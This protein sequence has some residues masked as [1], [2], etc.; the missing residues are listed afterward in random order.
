MSALNDIIENINQNDNSDKGSMFEMLCLY[1]LRHDKLC[2]SRFSDVWLWHQ[3][4]GSEGKPDIGIDIA[5]KFR[6]SDSYCAVQCKFRQDDKSIA[7]KEIDSFFS[8]SS[9]IFFSQ[10][11]LFALTAEFNDKAESIIH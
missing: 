1:F 8:A 7:K 2:A 11:I 6:N 5:A 9:R 4:P 10:R 3:W